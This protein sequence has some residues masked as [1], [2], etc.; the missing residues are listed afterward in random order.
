MK[1]TNRSWRVWVI[2]FFGVFLFKVEVY[3]FFEENLIKL[4]ALGVKQVILDPG[5]GFGKTVEHNL[6]LLE[7]LEKFKSFQLPILVGISR[8]SFVNKILNVNQIDSVSGTN[9]LNKMAI[10]NGAKML[11]VHDLKKTKEI[12]GICGF[13]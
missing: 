3:S 10:E 13:L 1:K 12:I 11:R 5:F 2:L 4:N 9:I 6:E 8:K 7:N